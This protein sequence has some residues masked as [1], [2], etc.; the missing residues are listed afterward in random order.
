M[1]VLGI[2]SNVSSGFYQYSLPM[3]AENYQLVNLENTGHF[4]FEENSSGIYETIM[5]YLKK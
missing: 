2:A 4:M 5:T 1:P 3:I